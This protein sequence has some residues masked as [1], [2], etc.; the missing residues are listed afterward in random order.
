[1]HP[2]F[3]AQLGPNRRPAPTKSAPAQQL[4]PPKPIWAWRHAHGVLGRETCVGLPR[5]PCRASQAILVPRASIKSPLC[6][7]C[8]LVFVK[9]IEI[10]WWIISKRTDTGEHSTRERVLNIK[11][12]GRMVNRVSHVYN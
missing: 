7:A 1:L 12:T 3:G 4:G 5:R 8:L 9:P 11:S 2:S 10:L 6:A